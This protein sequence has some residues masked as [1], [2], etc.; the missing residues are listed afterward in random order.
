MKHAVLKWIS[1]AVAVLL[2]G[3][4]AGN[5]TGRVRGTD[6]GP[7]A[8]ALLCEAPAKGVAVAAATLALAAVAGVLGGRLAGPRTGL[9]SAGL[10]VAWGAFET[11]R[12]D[13]II[14]R[15]HSLSSLWTLAMEGAL[16]AALGIA[17]ALVILKTSKRERGTEYGVSP[18]SKDSLTG[19]VVAIVVG[20]VAAIL[21][22]RTSK[23]VGQALGAAIAAGVAGTLV[24][25]VVAHHAPIGVFVVAGML[26]A[27]VGPASGAFVNGTSIVERVYAGNEFALARMMPMDWIAGILLGVPV[28]ASWAASMV[29]KHAVERD[30]KAALER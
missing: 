12:L 18:F 24:G 15:T 22:A 23:D 7:K 20:A 10:V 6:G 16:L 5:L 27:M 3:P 14:R 25:R 2:L 26:L 21:V 8:T 4:V 11:A 13:T 19:A 17:A 29:D 1:L 9:F 30:A 28:G